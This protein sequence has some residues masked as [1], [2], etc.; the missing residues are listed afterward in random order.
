MTL[1]PNAEPVD[2]VDRG[3]GDSPSGDRRLWAGRALL[4]A[5]RPGARC[6]RGGGGGQRCCRRAPSPTC[7]LT[8]R[9]SAAIRPGPRYRR[10]YRST[11]SADCG[12]CRTGCGASAVGRAGRGGCD[13]VHR[14]LPDPFGGGAPPR[15]RRAQGD[16]LGAR[17]RRSGARRDGRARRELR[18][19]LRPERHDVISNA[20]V[21]PTA[22]HRWRRSC[23]RQLVSATD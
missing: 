13:R 17:Q 8:I 22:W 2:T 20:H 1:V 5:R 12:A 6:G 9:C 15:G 23:I 19:G 14:T 3:P 21:R 4:P 11:R 16:H 10:G 7:S 18:R